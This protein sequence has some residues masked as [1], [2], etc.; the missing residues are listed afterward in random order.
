MFTV[1]DKFAVT[2]KISASIAGH[3]S[4][5]LHLLNLL[6][7]FKDVRST[8]AFYIALR[9]VSHLHQK[10]LSFLE[11]EILFSFVIVYFVEECPKQIFNRDT[12]AR[13]EIAHDPHAQFQKYEPG[14]LLRVN[15]L[16]KLYPEAYQFFI[17]PYKKFFWNRRCEEIVFKHMQHTLL[18]IKK[19]LLTI[20]NSLEKQLFYIGKGGF[21]K[22]YRYQASE[23][24]SVVIKVSRKKDINAF[25]REKKAYVLLQTHPNI[26]QFISYTI[27]LDTCFLCLE[28][29]DNGDLSQALRK[30][31]IPV[32]KK[33]QI[34]LD[35]AQALQFMHQKNIVHMDS[36][37]DC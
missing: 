33:I 35:I 7:R 37:T 4:V 18:E 16:A 26:T 29:V 13:D 22:V 31:T 25:E 30:T 27:I 15:A 6:K 24:E 17:K 14:F 36:K 34:A 1:A 5:N 10:K 23:N 12:D 20:E 8:G 3:Q 9:S 21:S 19:S 2:D 32:G 28:Y 11:F